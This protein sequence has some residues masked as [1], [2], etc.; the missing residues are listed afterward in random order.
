MTN[1]EI[2]EGIIEQCLGNASAESKGDGDALTHILS[3]DPIYNLA[4]LG[5]EQNTSPNETSQ[6]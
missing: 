6:S 1:K 2:F 5:L 3:S 4:L